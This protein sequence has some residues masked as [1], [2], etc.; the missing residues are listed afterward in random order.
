MNEV[1]HYDHFGEIPIFYNPQIFYSQTVLSFQ[2][3]ISRQNSLNSFLLR[4]EIFYN[5]LGIFFLR[6]GKNI[7]LIVLAHN[8]EKKITEWAYVQSY[9]IRRRSLQLN[10][11]LLIIFDCVNESLIKIKQQKLLIL[12]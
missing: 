6:R 2:T 5:S 3:M 4:I 1:I 10:V 7:D 8:I 12:I 9:F 11:A